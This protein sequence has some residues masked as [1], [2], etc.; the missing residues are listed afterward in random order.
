[1]DSIST[2]GEEECKIGIDVVLMNTLYNVAGRPLNRF[3][4]VF[5][6]VVDDFFRASIRLAVGSESWQCS[7][8]V[9][10]I[11]LQYIK[12]RNTTWKAL[13]IF[14]KEGLKFSP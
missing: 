10:Y 5:E 12:L 13:T 4:G 2:Y 6:E 7:F 14:R 8:R 1:M 11:I 9:L 3:R